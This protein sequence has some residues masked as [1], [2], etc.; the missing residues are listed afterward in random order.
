MF[1][2]AS[3]SAAAAVPPA[4][5]GPSLTADAT[6]TFT[7][8]GDLDL[9]CSLV[10]AGTVAVWQPRAAGPFTPGAARRRRP[11]P[12]RR[13][14]AGIVATKTFTVDTTAPAAP[15][16]DTPLDGTT[17]GPAPVFAFRSDPAGDPHAAASTGAVRALRSGHDVRV[18]RGR[19]A[20]A[21]LRSTDAAGN[22]SDPRPGASTVDATAPVVPSPPPARARRPRAPSSS[23]SRASE[24]GVTY[25]C[26]VDLGREFPCGPGYT[27]PSLT[28]GEHRFRVG[29]T[30]ASGRRADDRRRFRV[31]ETG[32]DEIAPEPDPTDLRCRGADRP[33]RAALRAL[34]IDRLF[35]RRVVTRRRLRA[36]GLRVRFPPGRHGRRARSRA[37]RQR[38]VTDDVPA[39]RG[40]SAD[41]LVVRTRSIRACGPV[42][43]GRGHPGPEPTLLG[44]PVRRSFRAERMSQGLPAGLVGK[45]MLSPQPR[46]VTPDAHA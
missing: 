3:A 44:P 36:R 9:Q 40:P 8:A 10:P 2:S 24:P 13:R 38:R 32:E 15:V 23:T 16:I 5:D 43:P 41:L 21:R 7:V 46:I 26:R 34:R 6:P 30:D 37:A 33:T 35:A 19:P 1:L 12:L 20:H 31:A 22:A 14:A 25:R 18:R 42:L 11:R 39:V 45:P 4:V 28:P 27:R 29:A 17:V